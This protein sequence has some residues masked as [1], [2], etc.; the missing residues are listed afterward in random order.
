MTHNAIVGK[1]NTIMAEPVDSEYKVVYVLCQVRKLMDDVFLKDQQPFAIKMYCHWALHVDLNDVSTIGRFLQ[2]VDA[3]VNGVLVG[4]EDFAASYQMTFDFAL[5][6]TFRMELGDF[7][8]KTDVRTELTNYD[9][10][11]NEFVRHLAAVIEDGS[12]SFHPG[13]E[14]LEHVRKVTFTKG[15]DVNREGALIPFE[16]TWLVALSNGDDLYFD[17]AADE[18][19]SND[20]TIGPMISC[21]QRRR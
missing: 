12:L 8:E 11:W 2:Q 9:S 1:L 15:G 5:F 19:Q 13:K 3:Y 20:G 4:P 7:F 21:R 16:M 14:T 18:H 17:I 10:W 6:D